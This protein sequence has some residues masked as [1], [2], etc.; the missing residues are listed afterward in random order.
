MCRYLISLG[1]NLVGNIW[2]CTQAQ[3]VKNKGVVIF[4][5]FKVKMLHTIHVR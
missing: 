2:E 5:P 4:Q 3:N 1:L